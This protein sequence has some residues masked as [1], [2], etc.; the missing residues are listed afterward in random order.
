ML[1]SNLEEILAQV[2]QS[3]ETQNVSQAVAIIEQ[4]YPPD[5]AELIS[6]LTDQA[7]QRLL[8][9]MRPDDVA[10]ILAE[11]D[12]MEAAELVAHLPTLAASRIVDEMEP[13]EAVDVLGSMEPD[14]ARAVLAGMEDAEDIRPLLLHPDDTAGGLM[15]SEFLALRRRM[16][17]DDALQALHDWQ[18]DND[19]LNYLFVV[20]GQRRLCGAVS[21]RQLIIADPHTPLANIMDPEVIYV[22]LGT[23]QE[24][25][26]R[27]MSRYHLLA[28]PVVDEEG[29]LVGVI[30]I[31]DVVDVLEDEA[32][33]DIQR[34]GATEPLD[35]P[36]LDTPVLGVARRRIGW[37][38][39]LFLTETLTGSVLRHFE[40][41]LQAVV[42]LSF[43]IPLLIGTGGNAGSQTTST[44]IRA[45][46][47]GE[48]DAKGML[49]PLWHELRIGLLLGLVMGVV[50]Y[51]RALMWGTSSGVA[52]TVSLAIFAIVVWANSL[53]AVLPL[54][55]RRLRIDPTVVS[56]PAMSTLVDATGLFIYMTIAGIVLGL[57]H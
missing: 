44:I 55:A 18:P 2:R 26:A 38:L 54:L 56:G 7:Q 21:L 22:P 36:Y 48:F 50:A 37:L 6:E 12:E 45:I 30:T 14:A 33:E 39:L 19:D 13:D 34:L 11:M 43:F 9:Q 47:L 52:L 35:R 51:A 23:D 16:T 41:E 20:D 24:E 3:L 49:R 8:P 27:L 5:Q 15:T 4:F 1:Q 17:R 53:G 46:A 31:D 29:L 10:D 28:L 25:C 42:A 57:S 40:T 32:T